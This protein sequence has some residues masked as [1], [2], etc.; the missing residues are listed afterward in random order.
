MRHS[1]YSVLLGLHHA[2]LRVRSSLL[3]MHL[4]VAEIYIE[5]LIFKLNIACYLTE[6]YKKRL[7]WEGE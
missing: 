5:F 3:Q 6:I 4:V 7:V 1:V 2:H